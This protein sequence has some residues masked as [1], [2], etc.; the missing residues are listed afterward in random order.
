MNRS[1]DENYHGLVAE[2][3]DLFRGDQ[4]VEQEQWFQFYKRRLEQRP[5]VSLEVGCGTGRVLLPFLAAGFPIEGVDSSSELLASCR[6]KACGMGLEPVL[7]QQY[8][9]ELVLPNNTP[10]SSSR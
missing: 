10:R 6:R 2:S 1:D 9:Q 3:Y 4:P 7:Y 5:G 8:I